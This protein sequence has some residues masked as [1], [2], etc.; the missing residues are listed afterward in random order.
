MG[1]EI[2][3]ALCMYVGLLVLI[4]PAVCT[5]VPTVRLTVLNEFLIFVVYMDV[6]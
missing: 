4:G 6:I 1:G 5:C 2:R 3:T